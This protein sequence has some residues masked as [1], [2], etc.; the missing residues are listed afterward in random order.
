MEAMVRD[1]VLPDLLD[2]AGGRATILSRSLKT[3]GST[4][5]GLAERIA[6]RVDTQTNPTIAFLARGIEGLVVRISAKGG[7]ADEAEALIAAEEAILREELGDLV[8]AVRDE[9]MESVVIG[10]LKARGCT[11]GLPQALTG[12]LVG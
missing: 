10:L 8:F 6:A 11:L 5:S 3:W 1:T 9:T 12:R 7:S 4:E 2:R